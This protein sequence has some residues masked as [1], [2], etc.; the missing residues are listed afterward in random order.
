MTLTNQLHKT[1]RS[2]MKLIKFFTLWLLMQPFQL[3]CADDIPPALAIIEKFP[4]RESLDLKAKETGIEEHG[5][6]FVAFGSGRVGLYDYDISA[7]FSNSKWMMSSIRVTHRNGVKLGGSA[8]LVFKEFHHSLEEGFGD[9]PVFQL[10]GSIVEDGETGTANAGSCWQNEDYL[11]EVNLSIQGVSNSVVSLIIYNP[12]Y[13]SDQGFLGDRVRS[14][15]REDVLPA[16]GRLPDSFRPGFGQAGTQ[17]ENPAGASDTR[18]H[19]KVSEPRNAGQVGQSSPNR[20]SWFTPLVVVVG[21]L[22]IVACV[23]FASRFLRR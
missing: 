2:K 6:S 10:D 18:V 13:F 23:V 1:P 3:A 22:L 11:L 9:S 21:S 19:D 7:L 5:E 20:R 17:R 14:Y 16:A 8:P 15:Y 4:T 12:D